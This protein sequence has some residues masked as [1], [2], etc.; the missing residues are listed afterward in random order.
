[1]NC[2]HAFS[3]QYDI[4]AGEASATDESKALT[5]YY[6]QL[7]EKAWQLFYNE[8]VETEE[9]GISYLNN[10]PNEAVEVGEGLY[11]ALRTFQ[12]MDSRALFL[13]PVY[14]VYDR[15]LYSDNF[16]EAESYDPA[17]NEDTAQYV[18]QL[19]AFA[20]DPQAVSL[21]LLPGNKV[22]LN[23]G[24]NYLKFAKENEIRF[25]VDFGWLKNAAVADY[26]AGQLIRADFTNGYL[27]SV[28]GF[29]RNLDSRGTDY[30]LQIFRSEEADR[31]LTATMNYTG[32]TAVAVLEA[33][34]ADPERYYRFENG[35]VVTTMID[36]ADG[37]CKSA[38][39][40]LVSYSQKGGCLEL[41]LKLMPL[42]VAENLSEDGLNALV[43]EGIYSVWV[44]DN[45]V[46]YNQPDLSIQTQDTNYPLAAMTY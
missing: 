41:S 35:R 36:P 27:T 11:D 18:A 43:S 3:L 40:S 1:M 4:G 30:T 28:D 13:A 5:V 10:H 42:Y 25:F 38:A 12:N 9:K 16:V 44:A 32:P 24:E 26:I 22:Q 6:S 19:V 39:N 45:E 31:R 17:Q 29:M 20:N 2:A 21:E 46:R 14:S 33:Y 34:R 8:A 37:M 23:V 7:T 15:V